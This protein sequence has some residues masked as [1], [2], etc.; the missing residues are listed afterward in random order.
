MFCWK[1]GT[2]LP[3]NVER[4]SCCGEIFSEKLAERE[5]L[6][7]KIRHIATVVVVICLCVLVAVVYAE[8]RRQSKAKEICRLWSCRTEVYGLYRLGIEGE[9]EVPVQDYV[10]PIYEYFQ[11]D[12]DGYMTFGWACPNEFLWRFLISAYNTAALHA[13]EKSEEELQEIL[14]EFGCNSMKEL[15][16][17][18]FEDIKGSHSYLQ[19][20]FDGKTI[21][22]YNVYFDMSDGMEH[23][24]EPI[25]YTVDV[26]K[27]QLT[28]YKVEDKL[29]RDEVFFQKLPLVFEPDWWY[30]GATPLEDY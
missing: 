22:A 21:K 27:D 15:E 13:D 2:E 1:C 12:K 20:T 29:E 10:F 17:K 26:K 6:K 8:V 30:N 18:V 24:G 14:Q 16:D 11:F 9:D 5:K 19:Y 7:N 25:Y 4:C 3:D 23:T 28:V